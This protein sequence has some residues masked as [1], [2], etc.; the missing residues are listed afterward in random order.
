MNKFSLCTKLYRQI[1]GIPIGTNCAPL[2]AE[3]FLFCYERDFMTSLSDVKE[4]EIIDAFNSTSRYLDDLLISILCN[5]EAW[6]FTHS[7]RFS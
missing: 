3:L 1:V 5:N 6:L 7:H 2:V 4:F